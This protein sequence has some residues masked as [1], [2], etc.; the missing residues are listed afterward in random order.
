MAR[1]TAAGFGEGVVVLKTKPL[2]TR[3]SVPSRDREAVWH[4]WID[5]D[6]TL[7][8]Q[9]LLERT[10]V[11]DARHSAIRARNSRPAR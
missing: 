1:Q 6:D 8:E 7:G 5:A 3:G 4:G 11:R 9:R 10:R 2:L